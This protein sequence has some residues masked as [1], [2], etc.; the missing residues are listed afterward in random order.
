MFKVQFQY[1]LYFNCV[2]IL[3][4]SGFPWFPPFKMLVSQVFDEVRLRDSL[5]SLKLCRVRPEEQGPNGTLTGNSAGMPR[6]SPSQSAFCR[7]FPYGPILCLAVACAVFILAHLGFESYLYYIF[8]LHTHTYI[9]IY[10]LW[11]F[12]IA[13]GP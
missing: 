10:T 1:K 5:G 13:D 3:E 12:N 2:S 4:T 11:L 7:Q 9:Y 8:L 6:N